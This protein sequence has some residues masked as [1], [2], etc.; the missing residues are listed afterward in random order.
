MSARPDAL[1]R[2]LAL[3]RKASWATL[4]GDALGTLAR[5]WGT[6]CVELKLPCKNPQTDQDFAARLQGEN[7]HPV[8]IFHLDAPAVRDIDHHHGAG[9]RAGKYN[10]GYWAWELPEFPDA[11]IHFADYCEEVW[12]PSR[13][14]AEAIAQKVPVPVLC[15]GVTRRD[16]ILQISSQTLNFLGFH[17]TPHHNVLK[18]SK[19]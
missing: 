18:M 3:P 9:F 11:W 7:P 12:A 8:N 15:R 14:A 6:A 16:H 10:I 4:G 13:F 19:N 17:P 1:P 2:G 5:I